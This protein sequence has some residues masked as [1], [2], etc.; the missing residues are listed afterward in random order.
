MK[1][2][3]LS[4]LGR[5]LMVIAM[6]LPMVAHINA[7]GLIEESERSDSKTNDVQN[8][9]QINTL[10]TTGSTVTDASCN[11]SCDGAVSLNVSGGIA[12]YT[13]MWNNGSTASG[14]SGACAGV[15]TVTISDSGGA[16]TNL[17]PW[18]YT[19]TASNHTILV[20]NAP[21]VNGV[22][23]SPGDYIGV[24]YSTGATTACGGYLEW[25]GATTAMTVW[26]SESGLNNGF[27]P[28]ELITWKVWKAVDGGVVDMTP[29][30]SNGST[31]YVT[32]AFSFLNTLTGTY[33]P[34][35]GGGPGGTTETGVFS[36]TIAEPTAITVSGVLSDYSGYGVSAPGASDGSVNV[37]VSGGTAPYSYVWS[38]AASTGN[39]SGLAAGTYSLV[40]TD[41]AACSESVSYELTEPASPASLALASTGINDVSCNG[42]CDGAI[43]IGVSGGTPPYSYN[44]SNGSLVQNQSALCAGTY[45]VTVSDSGTATFPWSYSITAGNQTI[46]IQTTPVINGSL[47]SIGD[48]VGVFYDNNGTLACGGYG[49]FTG[50]AIPVTAWGS[51]SGMDNGFQAGETFTW[52]VWKA[53][54]GSIVDMN[55]T[56]TMGT[57][58]YVT[59]GLTI[60]SLLTGTYVP[61][62]SGS[63]VVASFTV[64]ESNAIVIS[65]TMSDYAGYGV[66]ANGAN[67]GSIAVSVTGG[68]TPYVFSWNN[69]NIGSSL[70][71]LG[72]GT[73]TVQVTDA[74]GCMATASY[75]LTEPAL[76]NLLATGQVSDASCY[77]SC[78]GA[79]TLTVTGGTSPYT[80]N[81]S[82][83]ASTASISGLCA[84]TYTVTVN[85]SGSGGGSSS[86]FMPWSYGITASNQTI[87]VQNDPIV[88]GVAIQPG[89]FIGVFYDNAGTLACGGYLEW[90]GVTTAITVWG[91]EAGLNNGFQ[92][93]EA[94]TWKVW[95][96]ASG[97][98]VDMTA[99]FSSGPTTY[100]TNGLSHLSSLSG[101]SAG[102]GATTTATFVV[103]EPSDILINGVVSTFGAYNVSAN[104]ASDGSVTIT[105]SGG[106]PPYSFQW[107]N[108]TTMQNLIG[109]GAG[110][111]SLTVLDANGCAAMASFSLTEPA[112]Q[113][114]LVA[115]GIATDAS[116]FGVC[117]G[118][119]ALSVSGGVP[120][121][122]I[123]WSTGSQ[124]QNVF[125]LC[126]GTY[127][128]TVTDSGSGGG[129]SSTMPWTAAIT[130]SNQT[131]L[132]QSTPLI[133]GIP[134][135]TGD[136][137][138]V[139]YDQNG[140]LAC[141]GYV[142]W[143]GVTNA[144]TIWGAESGMDNGFQPNEAFTWKAWKANDGA[145]VDLVAVF[146]GGPSTYVTNGLSFI[147]GMTGT[148]TPGGGTASST[149]ATFTIT[150]PNE[151]I[152][153]AAISDYSGYGVTTNGASDGWIQLMI[154]GGMPDYYFAWSN[155]A[156]TA[157]VSGLSAGIYT[158]TVTGQ[159]GCSAVGT[160]VITEPT[161]VPSL[162]AASLSQTNASCYGACD[163]SI[164]LTVNGG[165][166][167]YSY[168]W[169]NGASTQNVSSLCA[170]TYTVVVSDAAGGTSTMPWNYDITGGNHT[171]LV[172]NAP[173]VNGTTISVGDYIGVFY[174]QNGTLACGG[175]LEWLGSTNAI[176]VW[177]ADGGFDNG[178]QASET[179][180]WKVWKAIDGGIAD[181]T[182]TFS[183]GPTVYTTNGISFLSGLTGTYTPGTGGG[184]GATVTASFTITE[185]TAII[186]TG[187]TSTIACN[188]NND[189]SIIT[190][191]TGGSPGYTYL[192]SNG[193]TTANLTGL[194]AG[195]Y[196]V[197]VTDNIGCTA[198][199][200]FEVTEAPALLISLVSQSD[201]SCFG[202]NDGAVSVMVTGGTAPY[203]YSWS[204][205]FST[206]SLVGMSAGVYTLTVID[207][208]G[209][210]EIAT[211][212]ITQPALL[213]G[214]VTGSDISC[215][216]A[217]DGT[218]MIAVSGGAGAYT[219]FWS[220]GSTSFTQSGLAAGYY[221]VTVYDASQC[222]WVGDINILEPSEIVATGAVTNAL[223]NGAADGS[224]ALTVTGGFAPYTYQWSN[225]ASTAVAT[226][227]SAG[228][229]TVTITDDNMCQVIQ[230]FTITEPM[231]LVIASQNT[232]VS[233]YGANDGAISLF[234]NGG[235]APYTYNW[236]PAS[237][238]Q[239][240]TGLTSGTYGVTVTDM[241][242]CTLSQ[243]F[244]ISEPTQIVITTIE[245][246]ITCF[247]LDDGEIL[248]LAAGGAPG[249]SYLWSNGA[250][251]AS[252]IGLS[253]GVYT[254]T[255]TDMN[256]CTST[257]SATVLE[258]FA[259]VVSGT[260]TDL[261]CFG[262]AT[263]TIDLTVSGGIPTYSYDWSNGATSE[264]ISMLTAG[265]YE[266]TVTDVNGCTDI[267]NTSI[268]QPAQ[269]VAS[270]NVT[271]ISCYGLMDGSAEAIVSGGVSPYS[272]M[273]NAAT[274]SASMITGLGAGAVLV[275]V[276]DANGCM[277]SANGIVNEPLA[278]VI[279]G[280]V[281][282]V[283][284]NGGNDGYIN[285]VLAGGTPTYSY[286][287][288]NGATAGSIDLMAAG[289]YTLTAS[290]ANGC[291]IVESYV[292]NEPTALTVTGVVT[293]ESCMVCGDGA[294]DVTISGGTPI[295]SILWSNGAAS[296]NIGNLSADT[297]TVTITDANGCVVSESFM[298]DTD[299]SGPTPDWHFVNTGN[300]HTI[301][302]TTTGIPT[303]DGVDIS[304][305]DFIG[306][307]YDSLGTQVCGGYV[308]WTSTNTALSAWGADAG[309]DGFAVGESFNWV[310]W[311]ASD[312]Q[313]FDA[314]ASY[315]TTLPNAGDFVANG[316]SGL[317]SLAATSS[318]SQTIVLPSDWS[319]FSTYIVPAQPS[320][321]S[322][323]S[324]ISGDVLIAKNYL[325]QAFWPIYNI[326]L[327]GN[328]VIGEA[329]QIKM[330]TAHT[331]DI[332]GTAVNP[333][334]H[335]L[336][337]PSNWS[338]LGYLR[339]APAAMSV[340]LSPL[341]SL[342][343][344]A[345][346]ESG[347]IYWPVFGVDLIGNMLPGEGYQL[348]LS[349]ASTLTYPANTANVSKSSAAALTPFYYAQTTTSDRNQTIGI[350][351]AAWKVL[352][353]IG[354]EIGVYNSNKVLV[355]NGVY[356]GG[357]TALTVWGDDEMDAH[358]SG[359][360]EGEE[361][362][363]ELWNRTS[364]ELSKLTV[365]TWSQG[366]GVYKNNQISIASDIDI[367][368]E[369]GLKL[370]QNQ[371]NPFA[372]STAFVFY[373]PATS[374]VEFAIY[375]ELGEL[376]K[377]VAAGDMQK[378]RHELEVQTDDLQSGVYFYQLNTNSESVTRKMFKLNR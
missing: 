86:T 355:G 20:Q 149:V 40:V 165:V 18:N 73:Y 111:Y 246:N 319:L 88:N 358:S 314:N 274:G 350:P 280:A 123:D 166:P 232:D 105:V 81:W 76:A 267:Y 327:I 208:A 305:G 117:D 34:G 60:V 13:Y 114:N 26:G 27:Q 131:V 256:G 57:S 378:G 29:T 78:D 209:C 170:G 296:A 287:W 94:I 275:D 2:S 129:S 236:N 300:N 276:T 50:T 102:T 324:S 113:V 65:G 241:N 347:A 264:D 262:D 12:P 7:A 120:P 353:S 91:T 176:T 179:I 97:N 63:S 154:S 201:V 293:N 311:R 309:N 72:A 255:A 292:V 370:Y 263:G 218:A 115:S 48:V 361:F 231:A 354:D 359:L 336:N 367:A 342:V 369:D 177:G 194:Y 174:D 5:L 59:N 270:I 247:G 151:I 320:M 182:P 234:V 203:T 1:K 220:N 307:F 56:Y 238:L 107:N 161:S 144:I 99:A 288:S 140:T 257:A 109:V 64:A 104:G 223:C 75:I 326:N 112:A 249:Y 290:D 158:V 125:G 172:Q 258:P 304:L 312:Q 181:V 237:T 15:Y 92:A 299:Y 244:V 37:S 271:D 70:S 54:D 184:T 198:S 186:L 329:Y 333:E 95:Q 85:D 188:G 268:L 196:T 295:Y 145:I 348:K 41:A 366:T 167:P 260:Q 204:N 277:I 279:T 67:D 338:L 265:Y 286:A 252:A 340:M 298:V 199:N 143:L 32:N 17:M 80:Y 228:V 82:N 216:G 124:N 224:I 245:T 261:N 11:G 302:V 337:I 289:T 332:T 254:V 156:T 308:M 153:A 98:I 25:Q 213:L 210:S 368:I 180:T 349:A 116:C 200:S 225:G 178:F 374:T 74:N 183:N 138:G 119:I 21:V 90:L 328:L 272:Y 175:Y 127:T 197:T 69:G 47:I 142:E 364:N 16:G 371:P 315:L 266:V 46:L 159:N 344:I 375:N 187:T 362:T 58:Q 339:Q 294:V 168:S 122:Q 160:Y 171:I 45:S 365:N 301:L 3:K 357:F 164:D 297:Y 207:A 243:N 133:N 227:L 303:I 24:F 31:V 19:V 322:V 87:L 334:D 121:Y 136:Y 372:A 126:A 335:T 251:G 44:W 205:G 242:G 77:A 190:S 219:Y 43:N 8:L 346:N 283:S 202:Q 146:T 341:G 66:S 313:A 118:S 185:P 157:D 356:A 55:A 155:G 23:I 226:G 83:N 148:Y 212:E 331:I 106:M 229:Y 240:L 135:A 363:M 169:S 100:T 9:F 28:N 163:G 377:V 233:C 316:M 152:V 317:A 269:L 84:G 376:V 352:P 189:G 217:N 108:G 141:G 51:E 30:Y 36:F 351:A 248:A 14:L 325:G 96:A 193:A 89:D 343:E 173:V 49:E 330:A 192:W 35:S 42:V 6:L 281:T 206:A 103:G 323:F 137:V 284:C 110:T 134:I 215:Y 130:A 132:I 191:V 230:S 310:I 306:V 33:T 68:T 278:L 93:N 53:S 239:N 147:S 250:S 79:I 345:K 195:I 222:M 214:T 318:Q 61:S 373:L 259:M 128:V 71:G 101:S 39:I 360:L 38:N 253:A 291:Q 10:S 273:W 235:V 285:I 211:Y 52:K 22:A 150:E 321:D 221:S 139:F 282:D 62:G 162:A 4:L